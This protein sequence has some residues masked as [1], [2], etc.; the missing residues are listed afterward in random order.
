MSTPIEQSA[1][2][3]ARDIA[4]GRVKATEVCDAF[5]AR[6]REEEPRIGAFNTVIHERAMTEARA[7]DT[8]RASGAEAKPLLG[9]PVAI[10]DNMCTAG[11]P[12]TAS[13]R[14]LRGF[15]PPYSATVVS[16]LEAA[17]AIVVGKTNLDE[18]AM[19]SSTENSSNG[20]TR[21]PWDITR[22][23]GGSSGGSAA[24]VAAKMVPVS[25]GSDTGGSIRQPAALLRPRRPEADLRTRVPLRAARV[26]LVARSDRPVR[27]HRRGRRAGAAGDR[28]PRC[29]RC[30]VVHRTRPR[31]RGG[32]RPRRVGACASACR[33][34][35]WVK[36]WTPMCSRR[37]PPRW[38]AGAL[39]APSSWTSNCPTPG[40]PFRCTT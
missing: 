11:V 4:A 34:R 13:S 17:G 37:S 3:I 22:T 19:G 5:L 36:A 1:R 28:G 32:R 26:C 27:P 12:T 25:L 39:P 14:V 8:S 31:L 29:A 38:I 2:A 35:S 24:A 6:I 7:V 21:N 23:P 20:P 16:R 18:F 10:K 15:V 33:V 9:V 40:T 30:H